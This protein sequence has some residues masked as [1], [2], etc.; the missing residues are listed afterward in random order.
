MNKEREPSENRPGES[1]DEEPEVT[2]TELAASNEVPGDGDRLDQGAEMNDVDEEENTSTVLELSDAIVDEEGEIQ[3]AGADDEQFD[4][5]M[6]DD[7]IGTVINER[8]Q[9]DGVIAKGGMGVVFK[10]QHKT[11]NRPVVVKVLR[12]EEVQSDTARARFEREARR[13]CQLDHPNIVT[14]HDFGYHEGLGYLV[15][16]FVDGITLSD[17]LKEH[18]PLTFYQFAPVAAAILKGLSEAHRFD[19]IHRDIKASNIMLSF[20]GRHVR[21]V[22]ILDFGLAKLVEGGEDDLTK[23]SELIGTI[24]A[25]APERILGKDADERVDL[26]AFGITA[27]RMLSGARPFE[28][29]DVRVLYQHVHDDP[30]LLTDNVPEEHEIPATVME[31][32]HRLL[33]KNPDDRP[34]DAGEARTW[35]YS[36]VEDSSV[37]R[38]DEQKVPWKDAKEAIT[39]SDTT[40]ITPAEP[41]WTGAPNSGSFRSVLQKRPDSEDLDIDGPEDDPTMAISDTV[42]LRWAGTAVV[43]IAALATVGWLITSNAS[44]SSPDAEEESSGSVAEAEGAAP[45]E[46]NSGAASE[47]EGGEEEKGGE[48]RR[49]QI[50]AVFDEID[51]ALDKGNFGTAQTL[52]KSVGDSLAS[53]PKLLA[54]AADY[55]TRIKV[56]QKLQEAERLDRGNE[57]EKA[58]EKYNEVL[59]LQAGNEK[60]KERVDELSSSIF[61]EV[62]AN[63]Q[64]TVYAEGERIGKTP[65]AQLVSADVSVVKVKRSGYYDWSERISSDGGSR[66]ELS[67]RLRPVAR[68]GSSGGGGRESEGS[69]ESEGGTLEPGGGSGESSLD[70]DG[71][72]DMDD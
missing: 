21:R 16:E 51:T 42:N 17:Y 70:D 29:E 20:E 1:A 38:L 25:M 45:E 62:E 53:H 55:R 13:V 72:M 8:Y 40:Q 48:K 49:K 9:I 19:I 69:D 65:V 56:G 39:E 68:A 34:A 50:K 35:L 15:M 28:G 14:V 67:A 46:N 24:A 61:L 71:L 47:D 31:F 57:I 11:L 59:N 18:G 10:A 58:L 3:P 12:P 30:P 43:V 66:V 54:K 63:I 41:S 5:S 44:Q 2:K 27:Y 22:K 33:A 52:L 37:F 36:T 7:F 4:S 6:V 23:K 26:Y 60:A 32:V 64:G